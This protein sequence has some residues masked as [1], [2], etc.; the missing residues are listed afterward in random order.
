MEFV[1]LVDIRY[2]WSIIG[3]LHTHVLPRSASYD[4]IGHHAWESTRIDKLDGENWDPLAFSI[5]K[6]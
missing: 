6:L 5:R 4:V 3:R 2:R 1:C